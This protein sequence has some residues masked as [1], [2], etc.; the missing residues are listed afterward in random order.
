MNARAWNPGRLTPLAAA[1]LACT[2]MANP[3]RAQFNQE[4]RTNRTAGLPAPV[5]QLSLPAGLRAQRLADDAQLVLEVASDTAPADGRTA[6]ALTLRLFDRNGRPVTAATEVL[7]STSRGLLRLPGA[8]IDE[9]P[10]RELRLAVRDG[11][12]TLDLVAS[13]DAG[14]AELL[15]QSGNVRVAGS[16]RLVPER[17]SMVAV[18]VVE[19][20]LNLD[21]LDAS[22]ISPP[23]ADDGFELEI[24][25]NLAGD[26][27]D[28]STLGARTAFFLKGMV[29][30]DVL[31]TLAYDSEKD[32]RDRLFRDILP[33]QFYPIYGDSS[34]KGF[35][36]QSR[37]RLYVRVDR[38]RSFVLYGDFNTAAGGPSRELSRYSRS[39]SGLKLHHEGE[40]FEV[41]AWLVNDNVAQV[42]DEQPAR[43]ISGPYRLSNQNGVSG[44]EKVE[45][46]T[47][48][49]NQPGIILRRE[50][51]V[52]FVDYEFEPFAG[53]IIF[54]APVPSVDANLNPITVR[55]TYE[56]E[57]GGPKYWLGGIDG[58]V[59]ITPSVEVGGSHVESQDPSDPYRLSGVSATVTLGGRT[60]AMLEVARS[61]REALGDQG[62]GTG[63]RAEVRHQGEALD[64]RVWA[65][66]TD[67]AFSN[68]SSS[69][70][71]GRAEAGVTATWKIDEK[72]SVRVDAI[73]SRDKAIDAVRETGYAGVS[74]ALTPE[75]TVGVGIRHGRDEGGVPNAA[76]ASGV[77]IP[78]QP[79]F[80]PFQ[81]NAPLFAAEPGQVREFD[82]LSINAQGKLTERLSVLG[83][84]EQDVSDARGQ[85]ITLGADYRLNEQTRAYGRAE[86]SKGLGGVNGLSLDGRETALVA[87]VSSEVV[88]DTELFNEYR[89]RDAISG[90]DAVNAIGLRRLFPVAEGI[91]YSASA[92]HQKAVAGDSA[93]ATALTG[94]VELTHDPRWRAT[95]RLEWRRDRNFDAWLSTLGATHKVDRDWSLLARNTLSVQNARNPSVH[96]QWQDRFQVG[97]AYRQTDLNRVNALALYE[98]RTQQDKNPAIDEKRVSHIVSLHADHHPSRPWWLTGRI[99]GKRVNERFAGGV[100]D[101]YTAWLAGG[102]ITWDVTERWDVGVQH[103]RLW[104]RDGGARQASTGIEAGYLVK[105]NLW[106]SVGYN[107]RGFR[108]DELQGSAYTQKGVYVRLRFKFDETLFR[109]DDPSSNRSL[110]R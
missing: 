14:D 27:G 48:D 64:A 82:A 63:A 99:A 36:A 2:L 4:E 31:L 69:Y 6:I 52:R 76:S 20:T 32:Q 34:I 72:F 21:K 11:V 96:D 8:A 16:V 93:S 55:V 56:V 77:N 81:I 60:W 74:Y 110:P 101:D 66:D 104:S 25:R 9:P 3:A 40:G 73:R 5:T 1:A 65:G 39:V 103:H 7:V 28:R 97:A 23:R 42:V 10:R 58:Q 49:R 43:G 83:E 78:Q 24:R 62:R 29:R 41:N 71:G 50:P 87:G 70:N 88:R 59:R 107:V 68:I 18:G 86:V 37:E 94:G 44:S 26:A 90:R 80:T 92:E 84:F 22:D 47:R 12:A 61:E 105:S 54:R 89:L 15:V 67:R 19:G 108:D 75:W 79:G 46:V 57:Q 85:R 91:R 53:S 38:D 95:G 45:L 35:D 106:L 98:L 30:G 100:R 102:R 109:G 51:M 13:A 17:R 33:D